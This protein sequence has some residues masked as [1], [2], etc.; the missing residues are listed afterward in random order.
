MDVINNLPQRP[1]V[2][3]LSDKPSYDEV[4]FAVS[5]L[6]SG[7]APDINGFTA[8]IVKSGG[9]NMITLLG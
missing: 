3:C 2:Q 1:I 4:A 5:K 7:K 8:E 9:E 6:N